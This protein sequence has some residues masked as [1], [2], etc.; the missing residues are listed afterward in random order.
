MLFL[1]AAS[2]AIIFFW[3]NARDNI[4]VCDDT[5]RRCAVRDGASVI[6]PNFEFY[7]KFINESYLRMVTANGIRSIPDRLMDV[8]VAVGVI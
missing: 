6:E 3:E 2:I 4:R 5:D 8:I 7:L 1:D